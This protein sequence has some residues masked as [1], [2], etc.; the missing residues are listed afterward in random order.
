MVTDSLIRRIFSVHLMCV[1]VGVSACRGGLR[2]Q[3]KNLL[4]AL[5]L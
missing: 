1:F 2:K 5:S 3:K 4:G